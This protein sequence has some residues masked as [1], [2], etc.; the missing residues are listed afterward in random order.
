[1]MIMM[2]MTSPQ[3]NTNAEYVLPLFAEF[4]AE[5]LDHVVVELLR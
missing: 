5:A 4:D 2:M 1:M 3:I